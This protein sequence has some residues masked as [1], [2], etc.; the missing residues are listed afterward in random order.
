MQK[1]AFEALGTHFSISVWDTIT[2]EHFETLMNACESK[3][4]T[5]DALYSRFI[6]T[7]LVCDLSTKTGQQVVPHDLVEMLQLYAQLNTLTHGKINP[8]IGNTISDVGYDAGY[9]FQ[10][11]T[12]VRPTPAFGAAIEIDDDT[13]ITFNDHVLLDLGALGKGYVI[14]LVFAY[15]LDEGLTHYLVDGSGDIRYTS[16]GHPITCGLENPNDAT[17]VIG[18]FQMT[19]GALCASATNRRRWGDTMHHYIDP[20]TGTSPDTI[21]ATWVFAQN[22]AIADGI[23]S[24]LFF[25]APEELVTSFDFEYAI[26]NKHMQLKN[27]AGFAEFFT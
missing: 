6:P 2:P 18:T 1:Y 23:A 20:T 24:A 16:I 4:R 27:S 10:K 26:I 19:E 11:K 8:C 22:A 15:L 3:V 17:Q 21:I 7:S 25:T 12:R 5:F 13:H 14:D 9:S